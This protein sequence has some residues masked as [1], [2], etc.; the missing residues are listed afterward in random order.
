MQPW[1]YNKALDTAKSFQAFTCYRD[2]GPMRSL[3]AAYQVYGA[4]ESIKTVPGF[5]REWCSK[6]EWVARCLDFDL[7]NDRLRV[8]RERSDRQSDH[9]R[10]IEEIRSITEGIAVA[11]LAASFKVAVMVR[12][13]IVALQARVMIDG[14][15][16]LGQE[17]A[18][19]LL[20][21]AAIQG[22]DAATIEASLKIAEEALG[23]RSLL[24]KL[25]DC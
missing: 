17:D 3:E 2:L 22:K 21:L 24:E 14:R 9:D 23:I 18:D 11:R 10:R 7:E 20:T 5:F 16:V 8:E 4:K 15:A 1:E 25:A 13:T 19:F 12:D 6:G